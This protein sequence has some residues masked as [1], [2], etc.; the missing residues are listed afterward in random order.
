MI[1]VIQRVSEGRVLVGGAVVGQ[2][3]PGMLALV[4][5]QR[6][7]TAE[8]VSWMANKLASLRI[9]RNAE[10]HF[11][12][13]IRQVNGSMLLVSNFTVASAT[14]KGRR[15]SFD[16]AAGPEVGRQRFDELVQAIAALGIPTATGQFGADMNVALTNDGPATF[17][18]SSQE[19][20]V[21]SQ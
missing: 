7:D 10:K 13:D 16:A 2:I 11:D 19:S 5:V 14:R 4:A 9:F 6:Q 15:P 12:L 18:V 20:L 21:I 17:V 1:A 8:D 3:G